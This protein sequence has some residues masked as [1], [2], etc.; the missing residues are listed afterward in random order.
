MMHVLYDPSR[1]VIFH[2]YLKQNG[3]QILIMNMVYE[4]DLS[5]RGEFMTCPRS[6]QLDR[7]RYS[8]GESRANGA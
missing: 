2:T 5:L 7:E 1:N 3:H 4:H 6:S 8:P